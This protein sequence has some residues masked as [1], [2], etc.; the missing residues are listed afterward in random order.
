MADVD[1]H[2]N[3]ELTN[4]T[5]F[6]LATTTPS[7]SFCPPSVL[8]SPSVGTGGWT[9]GE[10]GAGAGGGPANPLRP[11]AAR[12]RPPPPPQ[13]PDQPPCQPR[14]EAG[15]GLPPPQIRPPWL[16]LSTQWR[17]VIC[18][19]RR[20]REERRTLRGT[21]R[22]CWKHWL[23]IRVKLEGLSEMRRK[24]KRVDSGRFNSVSFALVCIPG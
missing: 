6:D 2:M 18:S 23:G 22:G 14:P 17:W 24:S 15:P 12:P 7:V 10:A 9:G 16:L 3:V 20:R 1:A 5:R 4:V 19:F 13:N 11:P 8:L 21:G